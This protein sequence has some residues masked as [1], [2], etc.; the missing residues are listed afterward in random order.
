MFEQATYAAFPISSII[1]SW[2]IRSRFS[3]CSMRG[4]ITRPGSLEQY[5]SSE[6]DVGGSIPVHLLQ[7]SFSSFFMKT[8]RIRTPTSRPIVTP[9]IQ[10]R[11]L[12]P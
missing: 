12:K 3:P 9:I 10:N 6:W 4:D 7:R 2:T 8:Q 1:E 5:L 11:S